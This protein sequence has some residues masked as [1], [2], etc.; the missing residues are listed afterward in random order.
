MAAFLGGGFCYKNLSQSHIIKVGLNK[1]A[2]YESQGR[3]A[4]RRLVNG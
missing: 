3:S 1:T 2:G 4:K